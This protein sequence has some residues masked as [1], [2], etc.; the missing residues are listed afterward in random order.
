MAAARPAAIIAAILLPPLGVFLERGLGASF[1]IATALTC[2]GFL[3]GVAY[4]LF[5]VLR[6]RAALAPPTVRAA[7]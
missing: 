7:G 4:A 2:L 1:W 3:P 6:P 5:T